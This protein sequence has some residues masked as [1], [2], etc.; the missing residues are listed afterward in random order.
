MRSWK[1]HYQ[2]AEEMLQRAQQPSVQVNVK[3]NLYAKAQVHATLASI[4]YL[5]EE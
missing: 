5:P 1:Y 4:K 3:K 2:Q